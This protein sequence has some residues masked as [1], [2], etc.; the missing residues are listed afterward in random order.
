MASKV[1]K[2]NVI[3]PNFTIDSYQQ[4]NKMA[5]EIKNKLRTNIDPIVQR[6]DKYKP[7]PFKSST[8]STEYHKR[9]SEKS[10]KL[11]IK[12]IPQND[13]LGKNFTI[14]SQNNDKYHIKFLNKYKNEQ[15]EEKPYKKNIKTFNAKDNLNNFYFDNFNSNKLNETERAIIRVNVNN[16]FL[17]LIVKKKICT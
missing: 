2:N 15:T 10:E 4:T 17:I 13:N 7:K 5:K 11:P 6:F 12:R 1:S 16:I 8:I 14:I 3:Y 9:M